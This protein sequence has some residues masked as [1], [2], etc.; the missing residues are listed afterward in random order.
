MARGPVPQFGKDRKDLL[1]RGGADEP[2]GFIARVQR[3]RFGAVRIDDLV[4]VQQE[5]DIGHAV[6]VPCDVGAFDLAQLLGG[7][8]NL[9]AVEHALRDPRPDQDAVLGRD[10]QVRCG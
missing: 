4:V 5:M 9:G 8:Q 1:A 2:Q 10:D 7:D 6:Q 3:F